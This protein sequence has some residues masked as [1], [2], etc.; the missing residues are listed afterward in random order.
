[1]CVISKRDHAHAAAIATKRGGDA[2]AN[3]VEDDA[4]RASEDEDVVRELA[5]ELHVENVVEEQLKLELIHKEGK[6]L[7]TGAVAPIGSAVK[8]ARAKMP[9]VW[10]KTLCLSQMHWLK[11]RALVIKL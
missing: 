9:S 2:H 8:A 5:F 10:A 6:V 3:R 11:R 1:M 7:A 4:R